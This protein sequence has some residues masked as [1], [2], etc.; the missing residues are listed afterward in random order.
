[1]LVLSRRR[2]EQIVI[3]GMELTI[4]DIGS[5]RVKLGI[6]APDS[7]AIV[8]AELLPPGPRT[9]VESGQPRS[10]HSTPK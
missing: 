2:R 10:P 3:D 6:A 1:M 5:G 7:V 9:E 8:R 4:L